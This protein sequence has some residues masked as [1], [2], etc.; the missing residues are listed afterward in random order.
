MRQTDDLRVLSP[1]P[2]GRA[3]NAPLAPEEPTQIEARA[4]SRGGPADNDAPT[5]AHGPEAQAPGALAPRAPP[6][7]GAAPAGL[8]LHGGD[9]VIGAVV[10]RDGR[11]LFL[12]HRQLGVG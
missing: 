8:P 4:R 3:E 6:H 10:Q 9:D 5:P 7:V 1:A 12:G 11:S 2:H